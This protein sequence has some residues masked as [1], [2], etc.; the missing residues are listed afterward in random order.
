MVGKCVPCVTRNRLSLCGTIYKPGII[1]VFCVGETL[2]LA[3]TTIPSQT[4]EKWS[5][6]VLLRLLL[7][8][9]GDTVYGLLTPRE[10]IET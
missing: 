4:G 1:L 3:A 6:T 2:L 8:T 7:Y 5:R 10:N 9:E